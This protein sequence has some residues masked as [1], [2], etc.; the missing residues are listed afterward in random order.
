LG[1]G[2]IG[3]LRLGEGEWEEGE[4]ERKEGVHRWGWIG[5]GEVIGR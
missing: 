2:P 5:G 4:E 3:P 1:L